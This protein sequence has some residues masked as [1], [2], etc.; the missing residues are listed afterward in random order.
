M[1]ATAYNHKNRDIKLKNCDA[2]TY[3]TQMKLTDEL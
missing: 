1:W 2:V 3:I